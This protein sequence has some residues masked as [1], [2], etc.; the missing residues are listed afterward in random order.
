MASASANWIV[1]DES[2]FC[3]LQ[4]QLTTCWQPINCFDREPRQILVV[5]SLSLDQEELRKVEGVHHYEERLLFSLLHLRNPNTSLIYVTSQPLHPS[6]VDYYLE[7]LPGIPSSHA[8]N[9]LRLF[10]T[11]DGSQRPLTEKVLNRPRLI[12]RIRH[13]LS[14]QEAYM[15][16]F[17]S[18]DWEKQ[19]ALTL[20][21]PLMAVSPTL[22]E[23]GTKAGSREIFAACDVPHP[24]G[25]SLTYCVKD[26]AIATAQL[27][28]RQ[29]HLKRIVIKLNEGFSGE[30]NALLML[31]EL[32]TVAPGK[33]HHE[34]RVSSVLDAFKHMR[35]QYMNE[36]WGHFSRKIEE[37]GAIAEA[38]IEGDIKRSPSVQGHITPFGDVEILSTHD[39]ILGGPD[40]Q[41]FLGCRF[42]A[43]EA[44]RME[45][46]TIGRR[47]GEVLAQRGALE[48]YSVD[49][50]AVQTKQRYWELN[51]IEI[52]LRKG[53]TTHPFMAL[54]LLTNGNYNLEDGQF[55]TPQGQ[56]K[57]Y[58]ASDNLQKDQYRGLLPND[59]MDIIMVEQ[60]H[61]NSIAGTGAA[62]HLMGCLSEYGKLGLTCIGNTPEEAE[63]IYE[64]VVTALDRETS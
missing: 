5:P 1:S 47:V 7:L 44:Y 57:F 28:E 9:R 12:E 16:C 17:N 29:P 50:I 18:T 20:N 60:L 8:E 15:V 31:D 2:R 62:F 41:I 53:G 35:F 4:T 39:Q 48:R 32:A 19:L 42:P 34:K 40:G 55:Y 49:F 36:T 24:E 45:L 58:R 27:W 37:L 22:L 33:V 21:I 23:L 3:Q 10:S 59:L 43:D 38:F 56:P 11:Y 25:S 46:Q 54:Q 14:P 51:A 61:F 63:Q 26:L 30:G 13:C 6:I 52:N 64:Q